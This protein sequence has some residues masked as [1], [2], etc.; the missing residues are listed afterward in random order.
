MERRL[1]PEADATIL[2]KPGAGAIGP[3][4]GHVVANADQFSTIDAFGCGVV[5]VDSGD[6]THLEVASGRWSRRCRAGLSHM[7][8]EERPAAESI[9]QQSCDAIRHEVFEELL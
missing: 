2:R 3:A 5:G 1:M 9:R 4:C 7:S 6:P 8:D